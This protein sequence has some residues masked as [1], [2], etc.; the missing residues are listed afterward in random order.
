MNHARIFQLLC[1]VVVA[2]SATATIPAGENPTAEEVGIEIGTRWKQVKSLQVRLRQHT[3]VRESPIPAVGKSTQDLP[4]F[5]GN[6]DVL[7]AFHGVRRYLRIIDLDRKAIRYAISPLRTL[8]SS[9]SRDLTIVWND[10]RLVQRT[11]GAK[12]FE[13]RVIPRADTASS[14]PS[15]QYLKNIGL[16]KHDLTAGAERD[17]QIRKAWFLPDLLKSGSY[18]VVGA[19][20]RV[21]GNACVVIQ[22]EDRSTRDPAS[23]SAPRIE[24]D[25]IWLDPQKSMA[26]CKR[27]L[28]IGDRYIRIVNSRFEEAMPKVWMPTIN[29]IEYYLAPPEEDPFEAEPDIAQEM[30]LACLVLNQV[31]SELFDVAST[32]RPAS[33]TSLF[34]A[35]DAYRYTDDNRALNDTMEDVWA[36]KGLGRR[37]EVQKKGNLESLTIDTPMWS[38][39]WVPSRNRV[40]LIPSRLKHNLWYDA[41]N[42]V[43]RRARWMRLAEDWSAVSSV[44]I[45]RFGDRLTEKVTSYFPVD[46][47]TGGAQPIHGF[48]PKEQLLVTGT[49]QRT[50]VFWFDRDTG[51]MVYRRCGCKY[52]R[53]PD[54]LHVRTVEYPSLESVDPDLFTFIMPDEAQLNARNQD[55]KK[56]FLATQKLRTRKRFGNTD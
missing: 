26:L 37:K 47:K 20:E 16:A 13:Y 42:F 56:L 1:S 27:E 43:R 28:K 24:A 5:S 54:G 22:L 32:E 49:D 6:E 19:N 3:T 4:R 2:C 53:W 15:S 41:N 7:F 17:D 25:K 35:V 11:R 39:T 36:A 30:R 46:L 14:F 33:P 50:R 34:D 51:L 23:T 55:V 10:N 9:G 45:E 44:E 8:D 29:R 31:P 18:R 12:G 52:P 40:T 48:F 21:V 38:V